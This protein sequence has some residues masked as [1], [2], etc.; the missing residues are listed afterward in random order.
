MN[1]IVDHANNRINETI[2]RLQR[3][4]SSNKSTDKCGRK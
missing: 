2:A 4:E 3:V 1:K